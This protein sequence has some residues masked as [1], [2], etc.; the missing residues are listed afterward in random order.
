MPLWSTETT[1]PV[2]RNLRRRHAAARKH[3]AVERGGT[4]AGCWHDGMLCG[5]ARARDCCAA[6][7]GLLVGCR[8]NGAA[9]SAAGRAAARV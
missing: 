3:G 9:L 6:A 2:S 5:E 7:V 1:L 8:Q 4:A